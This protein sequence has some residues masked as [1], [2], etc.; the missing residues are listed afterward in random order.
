M[1]HRERLDGK[2]R[3]ELLNDEIFYSLQE[4]KVL[5]EQ[6]HHR[7]RHPRT[8][9]I[10]GISAPQAFIPMPRPLDNIRQAEWNFEKT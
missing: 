8:P 10:T 7:Y 5:I 9:P 6:W 4:V 1:S 3:D 2:Q